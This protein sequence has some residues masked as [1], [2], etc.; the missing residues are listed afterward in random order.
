M[1]SLLFV[2]R[3][4]NFYQTFSTNIYSSFHW[5]ILRCFNKNFLK[6]R[7]YTNGKWATLR[8]DS[9]RLSRLLHF[10]YA[11]SKWARFKFIPQQ[12]DKLYKWWTLQGH[13]WR[14]E[15]ENVQFTTMPTICLYIITYTSSKQVSDKC[16]SKRLI[17]CAG[18]QKRERLHFNKLFKAV[19]RMSFSQST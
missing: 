10:F 13:L 4:L 7:S 15:T 5:N 3:K 17:R 9:G 12:Y 14:V 1:I 19:A 16:Q 8:R 2:S 11:G 18:S 6:N